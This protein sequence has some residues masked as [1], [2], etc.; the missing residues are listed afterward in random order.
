VWGFRASDIYQG[1]ENE[2]LEADGAVSAAF[3]SIDN[4][5]KKNYLAVGAQN[6][7]AHVKMQILP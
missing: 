4:E 3:Q 1:G 5:F 7:C 6:V 2:P